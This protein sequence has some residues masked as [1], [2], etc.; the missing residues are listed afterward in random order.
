MPEVSRRQPLAAVATPPSVPSTEAAL[1]SV[2]E[3]LGRLIA[4]L[5]DDVPTDPR[6]TVPLRSLLQTMA[7]E[8]TH[9]VPDAECVISVVP[10]SRPD[11][12]QVVAASGPWAETLVGEEWPLHEGMLHGRAM[13]GRVPVETG[14]APAES[15]APEVF[16]AQIRIGRLVPMST[17]IPL[18]DGRVGMGVVGFW[19][20]V[21]TRF[22]DTE[23]AIMDR[24]TRLISIMVLGDEA[25]ESTQH[26]VER[27]RLTSEATRELSSSLDPA[28]VVQAIIERIADLVDVDRI[29]VTKF[30]QDSIEAIAGYDRNRVAARIGARWDLTAELRAA[31]D[32]GDLAFEG[33]HDVSGMPPDMQEQLSDVRRRVIL[34]LRA[35]GRVLG[36]LAVSRRS[37]QAFAQLD[38]E[39]LEQIALSAALALQNAS[40]FSESKEAQQKALHALLSVSDHLDA[41]SSDVDL[42]AR[43]AGTVAELVG[44]RRVTL[45]RLSTDGTRLMPAAGAHGLTREQF[46]QLR[47]VPC[48]PNGL[49][50]RDQ[51]V[52]GDEGFRGH[53]PDLGLDVPVAAPAHSIADTMA[54][55]WRAGS[56]RLGL[57]AAHEALKPDGFSDEDSWTLQLAAFAGGLVWQIK[58]SEERI[59]RLGDAE[60]ERLHEHIERTRSMEKMRSDFLKLASHELRG[61]IAVVRGYFSMMADKS[62]DAEALERAMPVIERKLN[63]MNALVNEMLETARLDEGITRLERQPQSL[64]NLVAAATSGMQAQLSTRHRLDLQLPASDVLVDV[65]AGRVE[66]ILRNLLDNAVKFSPDGGEISCQVTVARGGAR[67]SVIDHGL[68]IPPEQMHRLFTR[69]SRLVTPENSHISGTGL[70][71]YLSRELARLHGGDITARSTP[72]GGAS[73]T[74]TLPIC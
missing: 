7:V 9:V 8:G 46:E 34:P 67:V 24:F 18:P 60:A 5:L 58:A 61:P 19:R 36:I 69:F 44:A 31:I 17:G 43:F 1:V 35:G 42:Y 70:G 4:K 6:E 2:N 55:A 63:D 51:V 56:V 25:R 27:L 37:D 33:F 29:T 62:L 13:L 41:T 48:T 26:L 45:W 23:R 16:G 39:N 3:A 74:L 22:T 66:T 64:S 68:G 65:D 59:R 71:L 53:A 10:A 57:L 32:R 11:V 47:P 21:G 50:S 20:P 28:R 38:L 40:M 52:F 14:N 73:F 72:G 15:A 12:F 49:S 54:V 30:L